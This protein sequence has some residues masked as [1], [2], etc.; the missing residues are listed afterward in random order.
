MSTAVFLGFIVFSLYLAVR[1]K[2]GVGPQSA[3]DFFVAS[4]QFGAFLVFF[5]AAGEI[6]SVATMVGFA[7]GIYA[8]GPTYGI[9]FLGYI[10][11]AYPVGY[12]LAPKIWQA[13]KQFNAITQADLFKGYYKSRGLELVV[14]L[15]AIV[16]LLPMAQ[17]QFTGL[18]AAFKGLGWSFQPLYLV[19]IAAVLAFTYIAISGVR[20]SAYVAVLKDVL[21][22]VAMV[23]TGLAVAGEVGVAKVFQS[24]S[25]HVSNR[26]NAEQLRFSMSTILF[27][28]IGFYMMPI[29][30]QFIYT[31]KS[32]DTIRRTQVAMP[33]YMLMYPFLVLASYYALSQNTPLGSA[34]EA[35]FT[36]AIHLLPSWLLGVI[37]AAAALSGLLVLTGMCLAIGPIVTRNLV[38]HLPEHQQ[39][40]GAKAVIV[41]YLLVSI[42][43]TLVAPN[44]MLTLINTTYYGVTQFLPGMLAIL[45]GLRVRP[46]AVA[47]G[48]LTGQFTA[49]VL[50][51][52][53]TDLGGF[54][55]GLPCLAANVVVMIVL[56]QLLAQREPRAVDLRGRN[57]T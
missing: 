25:E 3:H 5:L 44:L 24:A 38:P 36:A 22:V 4:G 6:Y 56:N 45:F 33:L 21:M 14:A 26:M 39:K 40:A 34:N 9:W 37:T 27:Q 10:L 32:A 8:K 1:S 43:M 19:L 20:S 12:F 53:K 54:N 28:S 46:M 23:V 51:L 17:L 11:L 47:A 30:V 16:F 29:S 42:L 55:L 2:K 31:A 48:I 50:Y 49:I 57:I 13:G 52:Q 15:S 7:G 41:V 35:F 18:I